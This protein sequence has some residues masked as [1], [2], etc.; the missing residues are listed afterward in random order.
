M[1]LLLKLLLSEQLLFPGTLQ[2]PGHEPMFRLDRLVLASSPL[3]FVGGSFAP[4]LPKAVQFGPFLL[5]TLC[6]AQRQFS[7]GR[8]QGGEHPAF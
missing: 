7:G 6:S 8:F 5:Q 1:I 3:D 4:L 2:C